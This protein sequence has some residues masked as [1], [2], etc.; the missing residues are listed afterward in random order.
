V[1]GLSADGIADWPAL[2]ARLNRQ[3]YQSDS[4]QSVCTSR[5]G[6]LDPS[7]RR[8]RLCNAGHN[9]VI[10]VSPASELPWLRLKGLA[11]GLVKKPQELAAS[12]AALAGTAPRQDDITST[13]VQ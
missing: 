10:L 9:P 8:L 6:V 7:P 2:M 5:I 11:L 13:L 12:V 4:L 3:T 1:R